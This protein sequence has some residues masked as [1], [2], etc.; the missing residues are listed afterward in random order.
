MHIHR[1]LTNTAVFLLLAVILISGCSFAD[2]G[3]SHASVSETKR[4]NLQQGQGDA[5]SFKV[6]IFREGKKN[7]IHFDLFYNRD[8]LAMFAKGYLG[9]GVLKGLIVKDSILAFFP[10]ENEYYSGGID[11]LI[12]N[13][14]LERIRFEP[15]ILELFRKLPSELEKSPKGFYL[16]IE[17]DDDSRK[18]YRLVSS[19]CREELYLKY[20]VESNRFVPEKIEY[21]KKDGSF[22]LIAERTRYRLN[23]DIPPEKFAIPIPDNA[24][25]INL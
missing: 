22:K 18:E 3:K 25:R 17:K 11:G 4:E 13:S 19:A 12:S 16:K 14:C 24:L 23:L 7:T 20:D 21:K 8:S 10:T 1:Y 15:L 9:K 5:Y 6:R 2:R